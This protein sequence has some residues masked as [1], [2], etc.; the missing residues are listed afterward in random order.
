[1]RLDASD[2]KELKVIGFEPYLP[3][4]NKYMTWAGIDSP[5]SLLCFLPNL[6]TESGHFK[7][8]EEI[9]SG[10]QYDTRVDLGNTPEL[11]GDGR[12]Y[13]GRG[14]GQITGRRNYRKFTEWCEENFGFGINFVKNPERV[15]EPEFAVLSAVWFWV[16]NDLEKYARQGDFRSVA[17]IW[18][19]GKPNSRNINGWSSRLDNLQLVNNWLKKIL[20]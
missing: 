2:F 9:A 17:S 12:K 16:V 15:R 13:K 3:Y 5:N 20:N 14:L 10:D 19:T 6:F 8:V 18:N 4:L 7:F 11:D 1:M